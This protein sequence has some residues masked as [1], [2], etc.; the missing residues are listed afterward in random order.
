MLKNLEQ[1]LKWCSK[2]YSDHPNKN[3][4]NL[5]YITLQNAITEV[6]EL[7]CKSKDNYQNQLFKKLTKPPP[8]PTPSPT[9][10]FE[11]IY[12]KYILQWKRSCFSFFFYQNEYHNSTN[13]ITMMI[14]QKIKI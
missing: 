9:S 13:K 1:K 10:Q 11:N 3:H 4:K 6:S 14:K 12:Y 8:P 7:V 2:M 5:D